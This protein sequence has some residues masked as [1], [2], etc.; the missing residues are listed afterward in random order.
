MVFIWFHLPCSFKIFINVFASLYIIA[1]SDGKSVNK[2]PLVLFFF[3][4]NAVV[5]IFVEIQD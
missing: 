3:F 1:N 5:I 2:N 4:L